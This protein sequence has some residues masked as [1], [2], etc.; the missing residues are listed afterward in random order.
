MLWKRQ[1]PHFPIFPICFPCTLHSLAIKHPCRSRSSS[2][3]REVRRG[4]ELPTR[5]F[6][7]FFWCLRRVA[8]GLKLGQSWETKIVQSHIVDISWSVYQQKS[9]WSSKNHEKILPHSHSWSIYHDVCHVDFACGSIFIV[10]RKLRAEVGVSP[11]KQHMGLS[12]N[13]GYIPNEIA[14]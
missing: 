8:G 4:S 10:A 9:C 7:F 11:L 6:V 14:I 13:V 12:E 1:P 3:P 5:L 2:P